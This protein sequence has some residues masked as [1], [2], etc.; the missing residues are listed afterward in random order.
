MKGNTNKASEVIMRKISLSAL[1]LAMFS[2]VA[3]A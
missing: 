1:A 3:A 2:S